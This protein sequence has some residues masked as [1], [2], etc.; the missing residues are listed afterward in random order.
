MSDK[1]FNDIHDEYLNDQRRWFNESSRLKRIADSTYSMFRK[2][3][4]DGENDWAITSSVLDSELGNVGHYELIGPYKMLI[5]LAIE[6]LIKCILIKKF[7]S[8]DIYKWASGPKGHNL[9][10]LSSEAKLSI[11]EIETEILRDLTLHI[12]WAGRYPAPKNYQKIK[13]LLPKGHTWMFS[14]FNLEEFG[15]TERLY[16]RLYENAT[17]VNYEG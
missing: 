17:A 1:Y 16:L 11:S 3:I 9:L 15:F 12:E 6:N 10:Y 4:H 14:T 7:G 5:G 2:D 8:F 13:D